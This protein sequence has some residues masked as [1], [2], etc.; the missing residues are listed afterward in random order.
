VIFH[1]AERVD[2]LIHEGRAEAPLLG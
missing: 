2:S 1:S